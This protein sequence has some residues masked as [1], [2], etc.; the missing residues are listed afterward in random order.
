MAEAV[1]RAEGLWKSYESGGLLARVA[2]RPPRRPALIDASLELAPGGVLGV[3]GESG[4]GKS[5]LARCLSLL[6]R[7]DRGRVLFK[8]EDLTA[9]SPSDLR[10]RRR[11]IQTVFQD[12]YASLNPRL[13]VGDALAEV[14]S[15]HRLAP[16]RGVRARVGQLLDQVGLP[17]SA[18]DLYP[19][20]FSG[21][22]R[23][24]ICIARALAAQP[25]VLIADEP[26]SS[27]DVSI[28][29]QVLN[30]LL[31]LRDTLGL[32]IVLIGHDL[33]LVSRIAPRISVMLGG[34]IVEMLPP[35]VSLAEARHPYTRE[36]LAAVP[37]L[38]PGATR[39]DPAAPLLTGTMAAAGCP[40][41]ERCPHRLD[42]RCRTETPPLREVAPGHR[43]ASFYDMPVG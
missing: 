6:E 10:V 28:R 19:A 37:R 25:E 43:V 17:A 11:R 3:V 14:L 30:L 40:Y 18:V 15:V 36:L 1:L 12:P 21:G 39:P 38:E 23:Q 29:A 22:Q 31:D 7:P 26:V 34:Q 5:T 13:R 33:L 32:A 42:P 4:S 27:L 8:G 41:W 9:P 16:P 20:D 2:A 35:G 24:R